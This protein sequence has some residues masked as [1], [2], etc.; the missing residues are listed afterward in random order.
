MVRYADRG[1][2]K[3]RLARTIRVHMEVKVREAITKEEVEC[4]EDSKYKNSII[5]GGHI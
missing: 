5:S 1:C 3:I 2:I 4:A